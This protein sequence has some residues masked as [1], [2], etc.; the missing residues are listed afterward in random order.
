MP[1]SLSPLSAS[2]VKVHT[3]ILK[4]T[5]PLS[6]PFTTGSLSPHCYTSGGLLQAPALADLLTSSMHWVGSGL[7]QSSKYTTQQLNYTPHLEVPS[8]PS[9]AI[10]ILGIRF[11]SRITSLVCLCDRRNNNTY[12]QSPANSFCSCFSLCPTGEFIGFLFMTIIAS[13]PKIRTFL[14]MFL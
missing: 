3:C 1:P 9:A 11:R 7:Q 12:S 5:A 2:L 10:T 13:T 8:Q 4:G 14:L 6:L